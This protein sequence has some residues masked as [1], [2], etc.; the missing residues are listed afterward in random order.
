MSVE[1]VKTE[2]MAESGNQQMLTAP[3]MSRTAMRR[4]QTM[5]HLLDNSHIS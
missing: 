5:L 2:K 3:Y 4:Q 1:E